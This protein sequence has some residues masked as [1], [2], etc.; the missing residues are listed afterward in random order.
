MHVLG[1]DAR[2]AQHHERDD[3]ARPGVGHYP[4][5]FANPMQ[6]SQ[7][8]RKWRVRPDR[9]YT[10]D[11][12]ATVFSRLPDPHLLICETCL[13]T[14]TRI[15]EAVGLQLQHASLGGRYH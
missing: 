2:L 5:L 12:T 10:F 7:A 15:S 4:Q 6:G 1:Y 3:H 13:D 9:I 11:E 14:A 8:C